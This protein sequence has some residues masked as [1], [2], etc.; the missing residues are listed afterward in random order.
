VLTGYVHAD[1]H[2]GNLMLADDGRLVFL[3]F[4][5][6]STVEPEI[7]EA[8][9]R[10]IQ[11]CLAEDWT[12]LAKAFKA[13]GFVNDPV[14]FRS[15]TSL[16][17]TT[18][19][20]DEKTGE[21]LGLTQF[22]EEVA[23]AMSETEG[24]TSRFGALATVLNQQLA[25]RWKMF[26][27]PY[28]LLLIRT[29]LTLEGIAARVDPEFNIYEMAMP[30]AVRRS[31]S[32]ETEEGVA[33]LRTMLLTEDNRVQWDRLIDLLRETQEA[34]PNA[35]EAQPNAQEAQPNAQEAQPNA[36]EAEWGAEAVGAAAMA[37][38]TDA[39]AASD[40]AASEASASATAAAGLKA[41]SNKAAKAQAMNDAVSSLLGSPEGYTLRRTLR[42]VD[43]T[44]LALRVAW[45]SKGRL[46]RHGASLAL[47]EAICT[48]WKAKVFPGSYE[49]SGVVLASSQ[50]P[51]PVS[52]AAMAI[53]RR[54]DRWK[55]KYTVMLLT[56]QL[57]RQL[58]S[59]AKGVAAL[60]SLAYL[61]VRVALG[62]SRRTL[63]RG[64]T[65]LAQGRWPRRAA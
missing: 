15:D 5:L 65:A 3:D 26:T 53:R 19:G 6:M 37:A 51:R 40:V 39:G 31:L 52:E 45:R 56:V 8:F 42:D 12:T 25:P 17:F 14:Q 16:P 35:Q 11:A 50:E 21:D 29:F 27:P 59:G 7:M 62:A 64:A 23:Q 28:V 4:G 10:G 34:Q 49:A 13:T 48:A 22:T 30:W 33:A 24:G 61:A 54:Q 38:T 9:A 43:S 63:V 18:F 2:E 1:P 57:R 58:Q 20:V 55:G 46:L 60:L 41:A 32:P 44:D 36:Q 47:C